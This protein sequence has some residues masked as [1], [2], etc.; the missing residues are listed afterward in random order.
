MENETKLTKYIVCQ[1]EN[2]LETNYFL[3]YG[4]RLEKLLY[5]MHKSFSSLCLYHVCYCPIGQSKAHYHTHSSM[6]EMDRGP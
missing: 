3:F 4:Q 1:M 5:P 2:K 6:R